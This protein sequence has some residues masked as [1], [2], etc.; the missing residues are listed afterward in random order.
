M[1]ISNLKISNF[2]NITSADIDFSNI[3]ILTGKNSSGKTNFL[4]ALANSINLSDDNIDIFDDNVV[5]VGK[6]K[7]E[8]VF[9]VTI[10]DLNK[11]VCY[12][13][14][15]YV[16]TCINPSKYVLQKAVDKSCRTRRLN[17][18]F[19]G[20]LFKPSKNIDW[21]EFTDN[22]EQFEK[23]WHELKNE[24]VYEKNFEVVDQ[25][26]V[27]K[28]VKTSGSTHEF[29][30]E[31]ISQIR[32]YRDV[33]KSWINT[34]YRYD[35]SSSLVH[36]YVTE[37]VT[38]DAAEEVLARLKEKDK[39]VRI[40][41]LFNRA[42]FAHLLADIQSDKDRAEKFKKE[43]SLYTD[44]ILREV[45]IGKGKISKGEVIVQSPNG[46]SS[47]SSISSGTAILVYFITLSNWL[48]LP[49]SKRSFQAPSVMIF[50]ELDSTVHPTLMASL[51]EVLRA[52]SKQTQLFITTHSPL[53]LDFFEKE[54]IYLLKDS[55]LGLEKSDGFNRCNIY[56][57][58]SI[59]EQLPE[60]SS[61]E[62]LKKKNSELFIS[63]LI[64]SLFH[65]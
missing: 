53:F 16:F 33:V 5:T 52:V 3:N 60:E 29:E 18:S 8:A 37:V 43:V 64:D 9:E 12:V 26:G 13:K 42:K 38:S 56:D 22:R 4:L 62:I 30:E 45:S 51:I 27:N 31:F 2:R 58:Q 15:E 24:K 23:D 17:L 1:K 50:D 40:R 32:D 39:V 47:I 36:K 65:G 41:S 6:G 7:R 46:A 54:E 34:E 20:R 61:D 21:D 57:Y 25:D 49:Y 14:D 28:T 11:N 35:F 48:N 19:S 63:G 55:I 59:I 10:E 44:G